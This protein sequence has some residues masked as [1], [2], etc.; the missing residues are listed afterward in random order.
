MFLLIWGNMKGLEKNEDVQ[1]KE[2][3]I[4]LH[5]ESERLTHEKDISMIINFP[6]ITFFVSIIGS[7]IVSLLINYKWFGLI[8]VL[9]F[10][11]V[12][13]VMLIKRSNQILEVRNNN[14]QFYNWIKEVIDDLLK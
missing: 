8:G 11:F 13:L 3:R 9:L 1:W 7:V 2:I 14:I 12:A 4:K 6:M 5:N 10:T